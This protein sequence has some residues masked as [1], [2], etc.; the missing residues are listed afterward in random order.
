VEVPGNVL[1][2]RMTV[3]DLQERFDGRVLQLGLKESDDR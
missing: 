2:G 3:E 1:G